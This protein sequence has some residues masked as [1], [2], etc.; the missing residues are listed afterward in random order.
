MDIQDQEAGNGDAIKNN[1]ALQAV[2]TFGHNEVAQLPLSS[3]ITGEMPAGAKESFL[4][5]KPPQ[6]PQFH[7][8]ETGSERHLLS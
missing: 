3:P 6:N 1:P 4:T 5:Q 8:L 2:E 7:S